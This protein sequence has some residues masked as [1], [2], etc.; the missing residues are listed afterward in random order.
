MPEYSAATSPGRKGAY[1]LKYFTEVIEP[2]NIKLKKLLTSCNCI[3]P[4]QDD[5]RHTCFQH[6]DC[7]R[8]ECTHMDGEEE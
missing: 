7:T 3:T 4:G 2:E 5:G 8:G 6:H 1:M